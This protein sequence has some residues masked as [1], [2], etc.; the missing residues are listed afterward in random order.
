MLIF[1][2]GLVPLSN[3]IPEIMTNFDIRNNISNFSVK[4]PFEEANSRCVVY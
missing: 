2:T 3:K 4:T 1:Q